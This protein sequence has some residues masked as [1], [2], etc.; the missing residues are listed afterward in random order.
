MSCTPTAVSQEPKLPNANEAARKYVLDEASQELFGTQRHHPLLV[1]VRVVFPAKGDL[2]TFVS[3]QSM[4]ADRDA[5][6]VA[7]EIAEDRRRAAEGGFGV[8]HPVLATEFLHKRRK[9]L[10]CGQGVRTAEVELLQ[11]ECP[12][13]SSTN[14]RRKT[15]LSTLTGRKK[16]YF[17]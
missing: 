9:L 8:N 13:K 4:I 12:A 15:R 7:A 10:W 14:L 3:E 6:S 11:P 2:V 16:A 5:M 17:G 1:A